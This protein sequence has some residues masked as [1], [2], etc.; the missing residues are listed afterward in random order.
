MTIQEIFYSPA[1]RE[2]E[3]QIILLLRK[4]EKNWRSGNAD[5][6]ALT[7]LLKVRKNLLDSM[8][9]MNDEYKT[10]LKE[11]NDAMTE[12]LLEMRKQTI[13]MRDAILQTN[14][15]GNS[16]EAI[17]KCFL[18]YEYPKNHPIQTYRAKAIWCVLNGTWDDYI[19]LYSDGVDGG[20]RLYGEEEPPSEIQFLYYEEDLDNWN[21]GL[22]REMTK[23]MHLTRVFHNLYDHMEFSIFD[24]LWVRDFNIEVSVEVDS[25][26]YP[27]GYEEEDIDP[28]RDFSKIL[29]NE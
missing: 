9:I 19:P 1:V 15:E 28:H 25:S 14:I 12:Q 4:S 18:G 21:E 13:Q 11:F 26:S 7:H 6:I 8:F 10:L 16:I 22:D 17:G 20:F 2:I 3:L 5:S 29:N 27:A 23:D 24:L